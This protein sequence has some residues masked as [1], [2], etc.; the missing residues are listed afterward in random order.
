RV[1]A[2]LDR[3][4]PD[5]LVDLDR[6][7]PGPV[8]IPHGL[9]EVIDER[10]D[11]WRDQFLTADLTCPLTQHGMRDFRDLAEGHSRTIAGRDAGVTNRS[12]SVAFVEGCFVAMVR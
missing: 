2:D 6:R 11:G 7:Q 8:G 3:A 10:L 4:D 12:A 9:D 5:R 1:V